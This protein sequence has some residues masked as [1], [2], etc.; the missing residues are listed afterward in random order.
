M[1]SCQLVLRYL[2]E[3]DRADVGC[4]RRLITSERAGGE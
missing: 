3:V 4:I 1:D 2:T